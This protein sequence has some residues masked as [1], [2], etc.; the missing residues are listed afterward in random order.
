MA[1]RSNP[2]AIF[3]QVILD[4]RCSSVFLRR[5]QSEVALGQRVDCGFANGANPQGSHIQTQSPHARFGSCRWPFHVIQDDAA[6]RKLRIKCPGIPGQ[7]PAAVRVILAVLITSTTGAARQWAEGSTAMRAGSVEAVRTG[8]RLP[9]MRLM[10]SRGRCAPQTHCVL[11]EERQRSRGPSGKCRDCERGETMPN[12]ARR[13]R[14]SRD[15][16]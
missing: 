2:S 3:Q 13:R 6:N 7:K 5:N 8:P 10:P 11:N 15:P 9:S 14:C 12:L 16:S 1:S 4:L